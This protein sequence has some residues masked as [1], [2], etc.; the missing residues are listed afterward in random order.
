MGINTI[1]SIHDLYDILFKENMPIKSRSDSVN[2][3]YL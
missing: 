2:E 1:G 3:L